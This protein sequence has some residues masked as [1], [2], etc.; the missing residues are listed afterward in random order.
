MVIKGV[1]NTSGATFL[2][3]SVVKIEF[4]NLV[5]PLTL[6]DRVQAIEETAGI[7]FKMPAFAKTTCD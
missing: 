3:L 2:L 7:F 1:K 4:N 6:K 5:L